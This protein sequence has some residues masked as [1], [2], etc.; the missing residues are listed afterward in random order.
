M[1][2]VVT[3]GRDYFNEA[4]VRDVLDTLNPKQVFVG[5]CPTGV[6]AIVRDWCDYR[7]VNHTIVTANWNKFKEAAGP[8]RNEEMLRKAGGEALVVAFKGGRGTNNCVREALKLNMM[9][10]RVEP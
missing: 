10:V 4:L 3:G 8:I 9:V 1:K 6:D 2:I 7:K 5:C